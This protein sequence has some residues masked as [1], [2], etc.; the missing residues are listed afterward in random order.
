[1]ISLLDQFK[2]F[3]W[4][5]DMIC[6]RAVDTDPEW[7]ISSDLAITQIKEV[8]VETL[9]KIDLLIA[10][11]KL[12]T[13]EDAGT[14]KL[15]ENQF[16]KNLQ[17]IIN[18]KLKEAINL[19]QSANPVKSGQIRPKKKNKKTSLKKKSTKKSKK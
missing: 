1:M 12:P 7:K 18:E 5:V 6:A 16:S 4:R 2:T 3:V 9:A 13:F 14:P 11:K 15:D 19:L 10:E 8:I 17:E